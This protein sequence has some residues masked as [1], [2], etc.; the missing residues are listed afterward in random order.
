MKS[1]RL[2]MVVAA[3]AVQ[4]AG[5]G[6]S[7][8]GGKTIGTWPLNGAEK[9][10]ASRGQVRV[11]KSDQGN[12]QVTISVEHLARPG[13]AFPGAST[14]VVWLIP[15]GGPQAQNVGALAVGD[16]LKARLTT[17]TPFRAFDIVVTAEA[18]PNVTQPSDK[19]AMTA[20]VQLPS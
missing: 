4:L 18:Q 5:C 13:D 8:L 10:P 17:K 16:D 2:V 14:Y 15:S 20:S 3:L 6:T 7:L 19:R 9:V 12:T 1:A 11:A